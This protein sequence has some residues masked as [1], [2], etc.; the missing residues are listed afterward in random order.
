MKSVSPRAG[1]GNGGPGAVDGQVDIQSAARNSGDGGENPIG[2]LIAAAVT[3]AINQ[4]VEIDYRPL[5]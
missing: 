3:Y 2:M 5:A 4:M 1:H